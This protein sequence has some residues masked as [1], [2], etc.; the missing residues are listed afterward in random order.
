MRQT[1]K[2]MNAPNGHGF[3]PV[4]EFKA[5]PTSNPFDSMGDASAEYAD[6]TPML[7]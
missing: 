7:A 3:L 1:L 5:E 4:F 6:R 2:V